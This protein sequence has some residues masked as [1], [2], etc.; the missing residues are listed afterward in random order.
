MARS[1]VSSE[2]SAPA[3]AGTATLP[4]EVSP[5][6]ESVA[7]SSDPSDDNGGKTAS[8]I[9]KIRRKPVPRKGHSKSRRGCYNCKRRRVKCSEEYPSCRHCARNDVE[10]E[11]PPLPRSAMPSPEAA[12]RTT[13]TVLGL[14]D[15]QFFHHFLV[16]A[17]PPMP[18][19]S[20]PTWDSLASMIHEVGFRDLSPLSIARSKHSSDGMGGKNSMTFSH[21]HS[22]ASLPSISP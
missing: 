20:K 4:E 19:G 5:P 16:T 8:A 12:L 9:I 6:T 11:Y 3:R 17:Y 1:S 18:F 21:M 22:S 13:P 7:W 10:C 14:E 15:L 2:S